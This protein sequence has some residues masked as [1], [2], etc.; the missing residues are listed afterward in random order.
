MN[1]SVLSVANKLF[2]LIAWT[3]PLHSLVDTGADNI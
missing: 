3:Q 1:L 2:K